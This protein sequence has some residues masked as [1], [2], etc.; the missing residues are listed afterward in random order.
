MVVNDMSA[1]SSNQPAKTQSMGIFTKL[2]Y[3]FWLIV[4]SLLAFILCKY[5][6]THILNYKNLQ[7]KQLVMVDGMNTVVH[8]S[9]LGGSY[10]T[11]SYD[12][13][14]PST[15]KVYYLDNGKSTLNYGET[16][17]VFVAP[18]SSNAYFKKSDSVV[19][20]LFALFLA[21]AFTALAIMIALK[22]I[23]NM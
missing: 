2:W 3:I 7:A 6:V 23:R 9:R 21:A 4:I 22:L 19:N 11:Y 5:T 16:V 12:L 13:K 15:G 18:N 1:Q 8:S 14:D 10:K 17:T 20:I